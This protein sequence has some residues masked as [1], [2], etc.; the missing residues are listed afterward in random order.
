MRACGSTASH[1]CDRCL[2]CGMSPRGRIVDL[3]MASYVE[4]GG[5]LDKGCFNATITIGG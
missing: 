5:E 4:L 3:T 2:T 1:F